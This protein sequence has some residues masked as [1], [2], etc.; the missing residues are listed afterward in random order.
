MKSERQTQMIQIINWSPPSVVYS[1]YAIS[2]G[3]S[4]VSDLTKRRTRRVVY[5]TQKLING[6]KRTLSHSD[7]L[8]E[9]SD[10]AYYI[11]YILL[12]TLTLMIIFLLCHFKYLYFCT[13]FTSFYFYFY[14]LLTLQLTS[15]YF[16]S[17][18]ASSFY[19]LSNSS[20]CS[21]SNF[22]FYFY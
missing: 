15:T 19:L 12:S 21:S 7:R 20:F 4:K 8:L 13:S 6:N 3:S 5:Y 1:V 16:S 14:F 11:W 10:I 9:P 2:E 17:T 22:Y 18:L